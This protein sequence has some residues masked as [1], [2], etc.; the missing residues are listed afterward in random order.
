MEEKKKKK[1]RDLGSGDRCCV[2]GCFWGDC[3]GGG[4]CVGRGLVGL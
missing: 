3:G 1:K 4:V 2:C